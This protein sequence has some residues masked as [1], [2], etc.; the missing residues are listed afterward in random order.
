MRFRRFRKNR[1]LT[2]EGKKRRYKIVSE[3]AVPNTEYNASPFRPRHTT[4]SATAFEI[5]ATELTK[6]N[7]LI[8]IS[9]KLANTARPFKARLTRLS[10]LCCVNF[11]I[12][13]RRIEIGK[14][15]HGY[16][17]NMRRRK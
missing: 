13:R 14:Y 9:P 15:T 4:A 10:L 12:T 5:L 1:R 7:R 2:N 11:T 8:R 6:I 17:Y 3:Y 16:L